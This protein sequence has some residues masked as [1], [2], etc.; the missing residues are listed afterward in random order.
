MTGKEAADRLRYMLK[1]CGEDSVCRYYAF[2]AGYDRC[3]N[4]VCLAV[5]LL[6]QEEVPQPEWAEKIMERFMKVR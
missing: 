3:C 2:K 6:E 5:G 4:A 1:R